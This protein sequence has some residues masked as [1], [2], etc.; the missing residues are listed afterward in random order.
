VPRS[1]EWRPSHQ[2]GG[3][4][5][6]GYG[7]GR[8]VWP[9]AW[10]I[11]LKCG[12]G[13][14]GS[15]SELLRFELGSEGLQ[16]QREFC[17][18]LFLKKS[19]LILS[20]CTFPLFVF[21]VHCSILVGSNCYWHLITGKKTLLR[22]PGVLA[23]DFLVRVSKMNTKHTR[24]WR[25]RPVWWQIHNLATFKCFIVVQVSS[26]F[27]VWQINDKEISR[28]LLYDNVIKIAFNNCSSSLA[29]SDPTNW[30]PRF[31]C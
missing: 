4:R 25:S 22:L 2:R 14:H 27:H 16:I 10:S 19:C 11:F 17:F 7:C 20:L 15:W 26:S 1:G 29:S 18:Y 31:P 23:S 28:N 9:L 30:P 3:D 24:V 6:V 21:A 5:S 13:N 12:W 8:T